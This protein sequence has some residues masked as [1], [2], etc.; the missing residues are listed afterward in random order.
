MDKITEIQL[1]NARNC[2]GCW[3]YNTIGW[4][5]GSCTLGFNVEQLR[6]NPTEGVYSNGDAW[7]FY[8]RPK[9]PCMKPKTGKQ[10]AAARAA[11]RMQLQKF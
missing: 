9:E 3:A 10:Y 5:T 1:V 8:C 7:S 2:N 11:K 6:N 4:K